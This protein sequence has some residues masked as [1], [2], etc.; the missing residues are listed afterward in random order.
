[1][2]SLSDNAVSILKAYTACDISDAL[3][4]LKVPGA[5]FLPDLQPIAG[6]GAI[7]PGGT[8]SAAPEADGPGSRTVAPAS[9]VLFVPKGT[10]LDTPPPNIPDGTHWA[11]LTPAGSFVV[12]RQPDGQRNAVCGGIM[13]LRI[14][15]CGGAGIVVA[16]RARDVVELRGTGLPVRSPLTVSRHPY[17]FISVPVSTVFVLL[18]SCGDFTGCFLLFSCDHLLATIFSYFSHPVISSS[19]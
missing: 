16:G 4:K 5:G 10:S 13:A 19:C 18:S 15:R 12:L 14:Q 8:G 3:L 9:T 6:P 1:M 2:A 17:G 11:D 7:G